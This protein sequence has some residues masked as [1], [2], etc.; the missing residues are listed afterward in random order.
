MAGRLWLATSRLLG[1]A[2]E[3]IE[4]WRATMTRH[5]AIAGGIAALAITGFVAMLTLPEPPRWLE[6]TTVNTVVA[7]LLMLALWARGGLVAAFVG[8][9]LLAVIAMPFLLAVA[10]V[11]IAVGPSLSSRGCCF[12]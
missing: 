2:L 12:R 5:G 7:S 10:L 6:I 4:R 8:R 1:D 3:T 9:F 11:G